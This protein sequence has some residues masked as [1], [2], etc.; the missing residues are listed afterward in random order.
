MELK[1]D[2]AMCLYDAERFYSY[3][4]GIE[5]LRQTESALYS[6]WCFTR[7]FMELKPNAE[8][9]KITTMKFYSYL[10]G[11]ETI[12]LSVGYLV[13]VRFTRTFMELKLLCV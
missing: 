2:L 5:T 4:Y 10:Y 7:T 12:L 1:H 6:A 13:S 3:L 11:I 8:E 9:L